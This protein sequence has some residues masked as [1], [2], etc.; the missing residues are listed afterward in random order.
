MALGA[1]GEQELSRCSLIGSKEGQGVCVCV[2]E[3]VEWKSD[4]VGVF[5]QAL[6]LSTQWVS[7]RKPFKKDKC[8]GP[9]IVL[10]NQSLE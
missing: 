7:P 8:V 5:T 9:T 2:R 10:L 3:S 4:V 6:W 1:V